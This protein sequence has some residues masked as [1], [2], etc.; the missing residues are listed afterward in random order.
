MG[1]W[2]QT[3]QE[4]IN[5]AEAGATITLDADVDLT[6]TVTIAKNITLDL[7]GHKITGTG[8][9]A[10]HVT[11]GNVTITGTGTIT[12]T[13][14]ADNSSVIRVGDNTTTSAPSLTIDENVKVTSACSYGVTIFG[15]NASETLVVNG[16]VA[17]TS[18]AASA[19]SGNGS[20][21]FCATTITIGEKA[22]ISAANDVAIYQPQAGT[23]TVNG[24]VSGLGG[25]EIKAG[26]LTVG[27]SAKISATGTLSHT[28]NNN[29]TSTRGYAVAIVE[30]SKYNGV[31][32]VKV[33]PSATIAG[34][35]ATLVD[36][37]KDGFNPTFT[38]VEMVAEV[39]DTKYSSLADA[40]AAAQD[41]ETV[42]LLA[43]AT[44][45][46]MV[47][48]SG[49]NITLDLNGK[50]VSP[51]A[52]TKISGG[53]IGVHN[54][55]GLTIND[56][57]A[58][59]TGKITSGDSGKVYA[60]VQ[61]TVKGDAATEP[62]KLTINGGN[63]EGYYYAIA[64]NG[65]RHNTE[66]TINDGTFKGLV[67]SPSTDDMGLAIFHPQDGKL[68]IN[69][70]EFEGPA[71]GV[72][73][74]AGELNISG[75]TFK[76]TATEFSEKWNGSGTTVVGAAVAI[77][78]HSTN[79]DI[80]VN[81]TGGS[82]E[83]LKAVYEVDLNPTADDKSDNI[84]INIEDGT[85]KGDVASE[86]VDNFISGGTFSSAVPEDYCAEGFIP[87]DNG[88]GTYGVK[89]GTY[90]AKIGDKGYETLVEAITAATDGQTV[91]LLADVTVDKTILIEKNLTIDGNGNTIKS[92]VT[93]KL[94]TFYVNNKTC[95]LTIQNTT[96]DGQN[97]ASMAVCVYRGKAN[98]TLDGTSATDNNNAG[99]SV[100]LTDCTVKNFTG[101]PGSYVGAVYAF[102]HSHLTLNNCTFTG[103]TTS[104]S[105][106]GASGADVWTGAATT[107]VINGGTYN[108]VFVNTNS[109]NVETVTIEGGAKIEELAICVSYKEDG[110]TN[111]PVL[112]I[113]NAT[114][115]NLT[116]EEGEP[117]P[118]E[119]I[120]IQNGGSI[121]NKP[122]TE[123][124]KILN[125]KSTKAFASLDD[126][127]E[128]ATAEQTITLL[129]DATATKEL[130]ADV[131]ID[132]AGNALTLPTFTV[133]D[134]VELSYA[135]V[136]NATDNTYKV[137][138]ATYNRSGAAGTQWGT[139]CLPFSFES[140]PAGYTLYTP[141]AVSAETL[142]VVEV[143]YPV[144][145]GTPVIFYKD[146]TDEVT[147]TSE[148]AS[149]KIGASPVDQSASLA[150]VGTFSQQTITDNLSSIYFINGDKFH[151]AKV[152]LTVPAYRAYIKNT[153]A[154][155]KAAVLNIVVD[156]DATA[157]ESVAADLNTATAIYDVNG[158]KL[159]APQKGIN[160]MKL[161]NGKSVKLIVK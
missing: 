15:K 1:V 98:D 16:T 7:N 56:S 82:F 9:R 156:G 62:A 141:S 20:S 44:A 105:T 100:T 147:M 67:N 89:E 114:V 109:S 29:G 39:G 121:T 19:I 78:Q 140:A 72:E 52:G 91:T 2:A 74:R 144:A 154:G 37:K 18:V 75:G 48:I 8:A 150:L 58:D 117:I 130:P 36:S 124:A 137:T 31:G 88:D 118:A 113:D 127:I 119:G 120:T 73:I 54:G 30:N 47:E 96:I 146:N 25:V 110:S 50:T 107:V 123:A 22:N 99:N 76:A 51:V 11:N 103:N 65:T 32:E 83:G 13:G 134:G 139:A 94:G 28:V 71:A 79:K 155:A 5:N 66:I 101:Y 106:S 68:T 158:R 34:P 126:A 93:S 90:V 69:G 116:T 80:K 112:T 148:N 21:G 122:A 6:S 102:S 33:S 152:S 86:N 111:I 151:Q 59:K 17:T 149:I 23:L 43:D 104:Q 77:S 40:I 24:T 132:A 12:S 159:S 81:I 131:T 153:S 27:A 55:A 87:T 3:L 138:T 160:I 108:E 161:A 38:G 57:S 64:G 97:S 35:I 61:V 85:F 53:L 70:G 145:A 84:N 128:A 46:A 60:A 45:N 133:T 95:N 143:E 10:L 4:Q 42:T 136:I 125:G 26:S 63:Y 41:D 92:I 49:K 135:N 129:A 115:T 157:I 14:I 142:T